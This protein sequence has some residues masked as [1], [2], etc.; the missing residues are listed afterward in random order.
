MQSRI[1]L[2]GFMARVRGKAPRKALRME[3]Q[4]FSIKP[5]TF[6]Q[7]KY[8]VLQKFKVFRI[9]SMPLSHDVNPL[10]NSGL[11]KTPLPIQ[12]NLVKMLNYN[13]IYRYYLLFSI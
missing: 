2:A 12:L 7:M 13:E 10:K 11:R 4:G 1:F 3:I 5:E 6:P 9:R 8:P